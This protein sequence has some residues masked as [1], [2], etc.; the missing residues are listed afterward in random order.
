M[1]VRAGHT[2]PSVWDLR[3]NWLFFQNYI[4]SFALQKNPSQ[5]RLHFTDSKSKK[6]VFR[7]CRS[8]SLQPLMVFSSAVPA[9]S[10]SPHQENYWILEFH[11]FTSDNKI[12]Q[13]LSHD[14]L[15]CAEEYLLF[16]RKWKL[17]S[18]KKVYSFP[19]H[20]DPPSHLFS[21]SVSC[22]LIFSTVLFCRYFPHGE[23]TCC[24]LHSVISGVSSAVSS[25]CL[26][27]FPS[28]LR[29]LVMLFEKM[30]GKHTLHVTYLRTFIKC[31]FLSHGL[32]VTDAFQTY[33]ILVLL[34]AVACCAEG[35]C[36]ICS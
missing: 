16:W 24:S 4:Q 18:Q 14:C 22:L 34:P 1:F 3:D 5:I 19:K 2:Q 33:R 30:A 11:Y 27:H 32:C 7:K 13:G 9:F 31:W 6:T 21:P 12:Q 25:L 8:C 26:L 15:S 23:H 36:P 10:G 29:N 20:T 28:T 17:F 35:Y